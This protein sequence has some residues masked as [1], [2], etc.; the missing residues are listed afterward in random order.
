MVILEEP[1]C[2][3]RGEIAV[4]DYY[5]LQVYNNDAWRCRL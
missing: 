5:I 2:K 3:T 4:V 1:K